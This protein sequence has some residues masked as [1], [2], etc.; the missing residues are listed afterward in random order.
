MERLVDVLDQMKN[1][2]IGEVNVFY[3]RCRLLIVDSVP[4]A[5][6]PAVEQDVDQ[7]KS[8]TVTLNNLQFFNHC[9][10]FLLSGWRLQ[11]E[12]LVE[13]LKWMANRLNLSIILVNHAVSV[14]SSNNGS[15]S[16]S[17]S[18]SQSTPKPALGKYWIQK[19]NIRIYIES[20][21]KKHMLTV[22]KNCRGPEDQI[23]NFQLNGYTYF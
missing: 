15:A 20:Q 22:L 2:I 17:Y 4:M 7:C 13:K 14:R 6:Y 12:R 8:S 11:Q 21:S 18:L 16:G 1:E 23:V 19:I 3:E 9:M 10:E 5:I